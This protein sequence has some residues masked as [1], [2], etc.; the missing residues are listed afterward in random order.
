MCSI[1][2]AFPDLTFSE[3]TP[4][5][6]QYNNVLPQQENF[7]AMSDNSPY[8]ATPCFLKKEDNIP[9]VIDTV[10]ANDFSNSNDVSQQL[11]KDNFKNNDKFFSPEIITDPRLLSQTDKTLSGKTNGD[12]SEVI[13]IVKNLETKVDSLEKKCNRNAHD[14]LLFIVIIIFTI[15]IIDTLLK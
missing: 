3:N 12:Y 4:P 10:M 7:G 13:Q 8:N 11:N 6:P 15:L 2:D 5:T 14:L 1:S 9:M